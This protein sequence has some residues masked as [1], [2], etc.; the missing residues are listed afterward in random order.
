MGAELKFGIIGYGKM[1]QI[2][3]NAI[4][5]KDG[6][7]VVAIHDPHK[8]VDKHLKVATPE[9]IIHNPQIDCVVVSTPNFLLKSHVIDALKAGKHVFSE[10]PPGRNLEETQAIAE[11]A[12]SSPG[13]LMFGFNHRHHESVC[14]AKKMVDSGKYGDVLWMRGR[15]GKSVNTEFG[16]NWRSQKNSA[17]GGIFLD[18]GIHMLDL[19]QLMVGPFPEVKS[20]VSNLYWK[21]DIEDNVFAIFRNEKGQVAS[22]HSTMT[23]WR[24]LFSWEIFLEKGYIV[25]NGLKTS[26]NT[27]GK[28]TLSFAKNRSSAPAATWSDEETLTFEIDNSW[29]RELGMFVEAIS[30]REPLKQCGINDA[31]ELMKMVDQ[32]YA[33]SSQ[34]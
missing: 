23:Q 33:S 7:S 27:Y 3:H 30:K 32:V 1:G 24:H 9:E 34:T 28:E 22:L 12:K 4:S 16:D 20:F 25:L 11:I 2:R 6:C 15:Y 10:K 21:G 13:Y 5:K 31:L 17:G 29:D 18:Q 14:Y 26:S 19:F 8:E